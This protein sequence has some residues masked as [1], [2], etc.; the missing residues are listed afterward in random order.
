MTRVAFHHVLLVAFFSPVTVVAACTS[1]GSSS[2]IS[3]A[4]YDTACQ[5]DTDC[6]PVTVGTIGCCDC[7]NAAINKTDLA[8]YQADLATAERAH[9]V[10]SVD[11]VACPTAKTVCSNGTCA[12]SQG[13]PPDAGSVTCGAVTCGAGDICVMNQFEGGAVQLPNDAGMCPD[14]ESNLGGHC[15]PLPTFH[16]AVAPSGCAA[17]L[18]CGC[19]QSVCDPGFMCMQASAGLVQCFLLAP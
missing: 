12:L 16:C 18:T 14:G 9:G 4:G 13:G 2:M 3:L 17:G 8:Q 7:P 1:G 19:A 10:C 15:Q 6:V 11:C 5:A